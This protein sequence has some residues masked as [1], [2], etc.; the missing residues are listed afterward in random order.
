MELSSLLTH[1]A[2]FRPHA[3]AVVFGTKRL[4]YREFNARVNRLAHVLGGLGV[5][6]A[7][8]VAT[9]LPNTLE[10]LECYWAC[11]KTG[12]VA[13]PLS[14]LLTGIGLASLVKD[15]GAVCLVTQRS[16]LPVVAAVLTDLPALAPARILLIDGGE[17]PWGDYPALTAAA[18]ESE[19][20]EANIGADDLFNI[21]LL[22]TSRC[23]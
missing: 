8:R 4:D 16:L 22:Y 10:L 20:P 11:A 17:A 15:S 2:R 1:H 5:Q 9:L 6:K 21:C 18:A 3:T 7:E 13:V 23:V 12:A 19:P 14:P